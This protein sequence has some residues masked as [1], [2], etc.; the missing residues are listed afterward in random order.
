MNEDYIFINIPQNYY[1]YNRNP[2]SM[3]GK[4]K[5]INVQ[6]KS[7]D[8]KQANSLEE[9]IW[10]LNNTYRD[11][12]TH[13]NNSMFML[14]VLEQPYDSALQKVFDINYQYLSYIDNDVLD[15]L[16]KTYLYIENF[17]KN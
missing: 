7:I 4:V 10:D 12:I 6:N 9:Y 3:T 13:L 14:S 15:E 16:Q 2:D 17:R 1:N 8:K 5:T 11:N